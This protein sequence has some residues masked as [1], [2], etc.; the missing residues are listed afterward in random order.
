[1]EVINTVL[2]TLSF[3]AALFALAMSPLRVEVLKELSSDNRQRVNKWQLA[4]TRGVIRFGCIFPFGML[5]LPSTVAWAAEQK[6]GVSTFP[7]HVKF[8]AC[9]LFAAGLLLIRIAYCGYRLSLC[10][11][12]PLPPVTTHM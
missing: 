5:F 11:Y 8:F 7:W 2:I 12:P 10:L 3:T 4:L 1:M 9:L 6:E